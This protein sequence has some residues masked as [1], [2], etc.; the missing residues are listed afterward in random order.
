MG[1]AAARKEKFNIDFSSRQAG[2]NRPAAG[3]RNRAR[4]DARSLFLISVFMCMAI[5]LLAFPLVWVH[6]S[7]TSLELKRSRLQKAIEL[8][9]QLLQERKI[10]FARL[11]DPERIRAIAVSKLN[12]KDATQVVY[13]V[14]EKEKARSTA[15]ALSHGD[16]GAAGN[17]PRSMR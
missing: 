2:R 4:P 11:S 3:R 15:V 14:F 12:M 5:A 9:N 1:T 13:I 17:P 8:E 6:A 10:E 7:I 16:S